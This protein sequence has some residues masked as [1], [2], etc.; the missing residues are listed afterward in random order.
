M[1][2]DDMPRYKCHKEVWALKISKITGASKLTRDA[3]MLHF[4][5]YDSLMV[6]SVYIEKH[7]PSVGGY[8]V[9]YDGGYESFSPAAVFEAGYTL[10]KEV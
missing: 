8:Y 3:P 6:G 1:T 4:K 10:V 7:R 2:E 9:R 5:G